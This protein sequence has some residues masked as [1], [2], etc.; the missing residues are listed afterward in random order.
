MN[1][2]GEQ[3]FTKNYEIIKSIYRYKSKVAE[4]LLDSYQI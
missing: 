4:R 2:I 1:I 3:L